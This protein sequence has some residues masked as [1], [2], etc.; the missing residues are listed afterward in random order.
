MVSDAIHARKEVPH[1]FADGG[2]RFPEAVLRDQQTDRGVGR[3]QQRP[4]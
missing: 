4:A 1:R 2:N 3:I